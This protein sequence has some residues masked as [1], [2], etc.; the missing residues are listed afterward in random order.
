MSTLLASL[1]HTK[2][3]LLILC[4]SV[5]FSSDNL[6]ILEKKKLWLVLTLGGMFQFLNEAKTNLYFKSSF[7]VD[8]LILH[9]FV[10]H[11]VSHRAFIELKI[12]SRKIYFVSYLS[13]RGLSKYF[14]KFSVGKVQG[15]VVCRRVQ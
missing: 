14:E 7:S 15:I 10:T 2:L 13:V 3:F 12:H 1:S 6:F 5:V 4:T 11:N 9:T 8:A